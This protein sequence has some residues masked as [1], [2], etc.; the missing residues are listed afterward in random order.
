MVETSVSDKVSSFTLEG[1]A[2][3]KDAILASG[4]EEVVQHTTLFNR[5][6]PGVLSTNS[7]FGTDRGRGRSPEGREAFRSRKKL[8][9]RACTSV[10]VGAR[11]PGEALGFA[12]TDAEASLG[13]GDSPPD[14]TGSSELALE[15]QR[16]S[17]AFAR[18]G[19]PSSHRGLSLILFWC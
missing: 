3:D 4:S 5:L 18:Q 15:L 12:G 6:R 19:F 2:L 1:S 8:S 7:A 16:H 11:G 9:G 13:P 14:E 17:D 10:G